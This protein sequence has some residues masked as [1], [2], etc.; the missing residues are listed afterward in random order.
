M[1][2]YTYSLC[3][4]LLLLGCNRASVPEGAVQLPKKIRET[5]GLATFGQ[6]FLTLNDSGGKARLFEFSATGEIVA[7]HKIKG[8]INRDWEDMSQDSLHYYI[9]DTGNN[10]AT[11]KDLTIY[12]TNHQF[13]LQD[14]IRL[15]YAPQKKFK[16]KKKNKYDAEALVAYKDSLLIFSK[17]RKKQTTEL[18]LLPK[19]GGEYTLSPRWSLDVH[20]LI[21]GGDY[22][23]KNNRVILTGY[24]P[25]FTQY[26][27]SL[28]N[29]STSMPENIDMKRYQ[30]PYDNAQV[31]AVVIDDKGKIWI[32]SEGETENPPFLKEIDLTTLKEVPP[33]TTN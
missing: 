25:D 19:T 33:H 16:K 29:F 28:E 20:C 2:K 26:I 10:Y 3:A 5:S 27:F 12:I 21:T 9:A 14:S 31:E 15:G 32:S 11:R 18:Y 30:L 13:E 1:Q 22:D 7:K 17:N 4:A 8:A 23:V 24:L 6:N